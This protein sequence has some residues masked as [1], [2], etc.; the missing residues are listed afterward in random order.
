MKQSEGPLHLGPPHPTPNPQPQSL[1]IQVRRTWAVCSSESSKGPTLLRSHAPLEE[2]ETSPWENFSDSIQ[3]T[4]WCSQEPCTFVE[5][6]G[7]CEVLGCWRLVRVAWGQLCWLLWIPWS[8]TV[9]YWVSELSWKWWGKTIVI[10][11]FFLY[12]GNTGPPAHTLHTEV[13][14]AD[15]LPCHH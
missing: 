13:P 10:G 7:L 11:F 9:K 6:Q 3:I 5:S 2:G 8:C 14:W 12:P 4:C 15:L 1:C